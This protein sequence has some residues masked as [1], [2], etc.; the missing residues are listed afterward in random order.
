MNLRRL[1]VFVTVV[2]EGSFSAAARTLGVPRSAVSQAVS[3]LEAELRVRLLNR[4]SRAM[5]LTEAGAALHRRAGPALRTIDEAAL[6]VT[7]REGPVRGLVRLTAPVEVG[8]RLLE[9][10]LSAFLTRN[11]QVRVEL[12]LTSKVLDLTEDGIDL[13]VRGGPLHDES[14]IARPLGGAMGH[15]AAGLYA[16]PAYVAAHGVPRRLQDLT[17]HATVAVR[18]GRGRVT[19]RLVGPRGAVSLEL[20]PQLTVDTW[21]YALRAALSGV[22]VTLLPD[23]LAADEVRP[24]RLVPVLRGWSLPETSLSL[25]YSSRRYVP[26]AVAAVRDA[27]LAA[28]PAEAQQSSSRPRGKASRVGG[29]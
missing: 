17:T 25:V 29:G 23:F 9:P 4:S 16:A 10:V 11:P 14:V 12:T 6:E 7:D 20:K 3:G 21:G 8:A 13:A 5:T 19:W 22:G 18:A 28:F 15:Q 26:R 27:L 24:G 1:S 2:D